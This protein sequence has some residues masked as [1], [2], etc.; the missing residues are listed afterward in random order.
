MA[1]IPM[2][3]VELTLE[4][5]TG[6]DASV[7]EAIASGGPRRARG[8]DG[9][10]VIQLAVLVTAGSVRVLRTWL[11]ARAE[12]LKH[13]RVVW[14]GREFEAYTAEEVEAIA[15]ALERELGPDGDG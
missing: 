1:P 5:P 15:R 10:H 11:L 13:T 4:V 2:P 9:D 8:L 12:R 14:G 3:S 6:E 7:P